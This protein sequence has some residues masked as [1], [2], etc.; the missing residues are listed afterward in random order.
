MIVQTGTMSL[1]D[2]KNYA[3]SWSTEACNSITQAFPRDRLRWVGFDDGDERTASPMRHP[4]SRMRGVVVAMR[5][6]DRHGRDARYMLQAR[7]FLE[8]LEEHA[9]QV[10]EFVRELEESREN[11][12]L[13]AHCVAGLWRSGAVVAWINAVIRPGIEVEDSRRLLSGSAAIFNETFF[14]LLM[15][16]DEKRTR[17]LHGG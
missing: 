14:D 13:I 9:D 11:V 6:I 3:S 7:Y 2:A 5:D 1:P 4:K 17:R 8:P 12:A 10:V 15:R 16:S